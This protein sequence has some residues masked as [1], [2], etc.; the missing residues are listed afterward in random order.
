[1]GKGRER[2]MHSTCNEKALHSFVPLN[3]EMCP[4]ISYSKKI[5][6]KLRVLEALDNLLLAF[7]FRTNPP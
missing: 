7:D 3:F 1:M 5:V 2:D 4:F 6:E